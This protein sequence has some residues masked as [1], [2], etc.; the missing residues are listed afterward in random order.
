LLENIDMQKK[1]MTHCVSQIEREFLCIT[2]RFIVPLKKWFN[3]FYILKNAEKKW[4][5]CTDQ[6][7]AYQKEL[8]DMQSQIIPLM[9]Q[10]F[11][12]MSSASEKD[13]LSAFNLDTFETELYKQNTSTGDSSTDHRLRQLIDLHSRWSDILQQEAS[14]L[15]QISI[16]GRQNLKD[17]IKKMILSAPSLMEGWKNDMANTKNAKHFALLNKELK[18]IREKMCQIDKEIKEIERNV[19]PWINVMQRIGP[20]PKHQVRIYEKCVDK[21]KQFNMNMLKMET[22]EKDCARRVTGMCIFSS[23]PSD[24]TKIEPIGLAMMALQY[25]DLFL[26]LDQEEDQ[27]KELQETVLPII[28]KTYQ[29]LLSPNDAVGSFKI[30]NDHYLR[31]HLGVPCLIHVHQHLKEI[32][33]DMQNCEVYY[34]IYEFITQLQEKTWLFSVSYMMWEYMWRVKGGDNDDSEVIKHTVFALLGETLP[35]GHNIVY[36]EQELA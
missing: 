9:R 30:T 4:D 29:H 2:C 16:E 33:S 11:E 6:L 31:E 17:T 24:D 27:K 36:E 12:S 1:K 15:R 20:I 13:V 10:V 28:T 8:Q 23:I 18:S 7:Q 32:Q 3:N 19:F 5:Q 21:I 22:Y 25:P 35:P 14:L 26:G 34:R